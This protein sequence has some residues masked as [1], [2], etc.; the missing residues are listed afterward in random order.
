[1][2][3][4][5][6]HLGTRRLGTNPCTV[7]S[8]RQAQAAARRAPPRQDHR[9]SDARV[10]AQRQAQGLLLRPVTMA[11]HAPAKLHLELRAAIRP[12]EH[13]VA[14]RAGR[15]LPYLADSQARRVRSRHLIPR[16]RNRKAQ[17]FRSERPA[18][19]L[20]VLLQTVA[21]Q[22]IANGR[23]RLDRTS[24]RARRSLRRHLRRSGPRASR[25]VRERTAERRGMQVPPRRHR[26]REGM[27]RQRA[28]AR[29]MVRHQPPRKPPSTTVATQWSPR[30]S[31]KSTTSWTRRPARTWNGAGFILRVLC[32]AGTRTRIAR[33]RLSRPRQSSGISW[34]GA[35]GTWRR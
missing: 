4:R 26:L 33:K 2:C 27:Q 21:K 29:E 11:C 32:C 12:R 1:M 6:G 30:S 14:P 28:R 16:D 24:G 18:A 9:P 35:T 15:Q 17:G 19:A 13:R 34:T 31:R 20:V 7:S 23:G 22:G 3:P 25:P 10:P 8:S 5:L